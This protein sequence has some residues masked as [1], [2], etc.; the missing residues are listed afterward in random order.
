M[1]PDIIVDKVGIGKKETDEIFLK[2]DI[3]AGKKLK[4]R[5]FHTITKKDLREVLTKIQNNQ[6]DEDLS[7]WKEHL[8]KWE[9]EGKISKSDRQ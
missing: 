4:G 5:V 3:E 9:L 8:D 2:E 6:L 1:K 7:G